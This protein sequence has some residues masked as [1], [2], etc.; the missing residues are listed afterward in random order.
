[1]DPVHASQ[2]R[3]C[4]AKLPED[5]SPAGLCLKC[6]QA[7]PIDDA[8]ATADQATT[9]KS[10]ASPTQVLPDHIGPYKIL[11]F[12]GEG[13]MGVVCLAEQEQPIRRK[14]ALKVIRLGMDTMA[15]PARGC[16]CCELRLY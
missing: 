13:G 16:R 1:V 2:C 8:P 15:S 6:R 14:V 12:L 7:S 5:P 10:S 9:A 11:D 3:Q 4:G